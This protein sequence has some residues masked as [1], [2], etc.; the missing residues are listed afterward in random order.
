M[1]TPKFLCSCGSL[2]LR[3]AQ[4]GPNLWGGVCFL[5][6]G[7]WDRWTSLDFARDSS[8]A[9]KRDALATARYFN[10]NIAHLDWIDHSETPDEDWDVELRARGFPT[11]FPGHDEIARFPKNSV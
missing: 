7:R 9:A 4:L 6:P 3:V 5:P 2:E 1:P 8:E 11:D 10:R